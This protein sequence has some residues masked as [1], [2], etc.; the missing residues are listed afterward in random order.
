ME[1]DAKELLRVADMFGLEEL[2]ELVEERM[3]RG[4]ARRNMVEAFQAGDSYNST[5]Q[6]D[7][8]LYG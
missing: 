8:F 2:K 1:A 5:R 4:L 6:G 7:S 3:V